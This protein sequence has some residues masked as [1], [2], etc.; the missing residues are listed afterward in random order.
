MSRQTIVW[1]VGDGADGSARSKRVAAR[2]AGNSRHP[3]RLLYLG[4]V[5]ENGTAREYRR[6]YDSVYGRFDSR[7]APT[8]GNHEFGNRREGYIPYWTRVHGRAPAYYDLRASGWQLLSLNSEINV[9]PG[10]RQG[11]WLERQLDRKRFGNCRIGFWH[12]P[13]YSAGSHG[14]APE[15]APLWQ[16]L[17]GRAR[18]VLNGHSHDMERL[19]RRDGITEFISGA[20]G[21]EPGETDQGD[22]RLAFGDDT[23][24]GALRLKL[25]RERLRWRFVSARGRTLDSG[26]LS[27]RRG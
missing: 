9:G 16:A 26:R 12:R 27:C 23:H 1:A 13:R 3:F 22:P 4:D 20:G 19:E 21:H 6:N 11:R 25:A 17:R 14:D 7:T 2:I 5:Y 24:I 15:L 8:P 10:S 18:A